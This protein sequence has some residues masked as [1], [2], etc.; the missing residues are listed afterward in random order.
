MEGKV[1]SITKKFFPD[2]GICRVEFI[3]PELSINHAKTVSVVGDFNGWNPDINIMKK[4][5]DKHFKCSIEFPIGKVY[6]FRYLIDRYRW[7]NEWEADAYSPTPYEG[8][9]NMILSC[10]LPVKKDE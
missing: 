10:E 1:M 9:F 3:L 4:D 5:R 6:E 7:E 8:E 2:K